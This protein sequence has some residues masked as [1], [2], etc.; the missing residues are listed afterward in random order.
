[1]E[2]KKRKRKK[3]MIIMGV[4]VILLV[5]VLPFG[6]AIYAYE[7][8]FERSETYEPFRLSTEDFNGLMYENCEFTSHQKLKLA[9][10]KLYNTQYGES[11]S[12]AAKKAK[13]IVIIAHGMG[14]GGFNSYMN[15]A[16]WFASHG[17]VV[18]GYDATGNDSSEG[19]SVRGLPQGISDL[20]SAI[21]Y[22]EETPETANIP[23]VLWGHSW[24]AYSVSNVLNEHPEVKAVAAISGWN[25][26]ADLLYE[27]GK[28][29]AG[30]MGMQALLPY[31]KLYEKMKFGKYSSYKAVDGFKNTDAGIMIVHSTD[32]D[33]IPIKYGYDLY[34]SKFANDPRFVFVKYEKKG[35]SYCYHS[36]KAL[37]YITAFNKQFDKD[38][39]ITDKKN[40]KVDTDEKAE[41]IKA[42]L[43]KKQMNEVDEELFQQIDNL[44]TKYCQ[45]Q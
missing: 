28:N 20:S 22:V 26:S 36:D 30:E 23:I 31:M 2:K 43:D 45:V 25:T 41:Y 5:T 44:Y 4:I 17:Y 3:I 37:E 10:Y 18:F 33:M 27:Q 8:S 32:D 12:D 1:M 29:M 38:F 9:G 7:S 13:A 42:H 40:Q 35:H 34:Y 21:E 16:D 19:D 11:F 6:T 14:G 24:G 39:G 15:A